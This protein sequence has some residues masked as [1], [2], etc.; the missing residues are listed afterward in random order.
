[1]AEKWTCPHTL[2]P[3]CTL[4]TSEHKYTWHQLKPATFTVYRERAKY[5]SYIFIQLLHSYFLKRSSKRETRMRKGNHM[6]GMAVNFSILF[7]FLL[8][9]QS[10]LTHFM[11]IWLGSYI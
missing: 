3:V 1:M 6:R 11:A 7:N 10:W 2:Y 9:L 4:A 8:C 5:G